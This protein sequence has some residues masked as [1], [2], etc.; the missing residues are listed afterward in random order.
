MS[1]IPFAPL[2]DATVDQRLCSRVKLL[3]AAF[4][5]GFGVTRRRAKERLDQTETSGD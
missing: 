3:E 5:R 4:A 2:L 1:L